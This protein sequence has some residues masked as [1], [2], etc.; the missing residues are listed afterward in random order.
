[1]FLGMQRWRYPSAVFLYCIEVPCR[2]DDNTKEQDSHC[3]HIVI[4][5]RRDDCGMLTVIFVLTFTGLCI[6]IFT[7]VSV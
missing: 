5:D 1:M 2:H 7:L 3:R 4:F 6:F